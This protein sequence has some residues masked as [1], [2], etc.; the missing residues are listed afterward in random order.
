MEVASEGTGP[1]MEC[2]VLSIPR[3]RATTGKGPGFE[4]D[5]STGTDSDTLLSWCVGIVLMNT[6]VT[7]HKPGLGK[8]EASRD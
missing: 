3:N 7:A 6:G 5:V 2:I 1:F 4:G 8:G